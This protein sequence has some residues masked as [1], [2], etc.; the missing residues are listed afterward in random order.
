MWRSLWS[1]SNLPSWFS[2]IQPSWNTHYLRQAPS[3][4]YSSRSGPHFSYFFSLSMLLL[5]A[6]ITTL[7]SFWNLWLSLYNL[8]TAV[9]AKQHLMF[10]TQYLRSSLTAPL[11]FERREMIESK[12]FDRVEKLEKQSKRISNIIIM[13]QLAALPMAGLI[14]YLLFK[15]TTEN[16]ACY[17]AAISYVFNIAMLI[18][19]TLR[20]QNWKRKEVVPLGYVWNCKQDGPFLSCCI[21][22]LPFRKSGLG[23]FHAEANRW[24]FQVQ[25]SRN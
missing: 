8:F 4:A 1:L 15:Y 14:Q 23:D 19:A 10:A 16:E 6:F 18:C 20:I 7:L 9:R 17:L 24:C 22:V 21:L 12:R 5:E 11:Y 25:K 3:A 13:I 2:Y